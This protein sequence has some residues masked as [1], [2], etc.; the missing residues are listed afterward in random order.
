MHILPAENHLN[1]SN[2]DVVKPNWHFINGQ[3]YV[4][5]EAPTAAKASNVARLDNG[6]LKRFQP[7]WVASQEE[8]EEKLL[9]IIQVLKL[10][11][12]Q[13]NED[14][15]SN[16]ECINCAEINIK[17]EADE[18]ISNH[19]HINDRSELHINPQQE[20]PLMNR[21]RRTLKSCSSLLRNVKLYER[22]IQERHLQIE[23]RRLAIEERKQLLE[24]AKFEQEKYERDQR[25]QVE[26]EERKHKMQIES[27]QLQIHCDLL[28]LLANK[29]KPWR[30]IL[31]HEID[32]NTNYI[33]GNLTEVLRDTANFIHIQIFLRLSWSKGGIRGRAGGSGRP[34]ATIEPHLRLLALRDRMSSTRMV[35]DEFFVDEGIRFTS[36]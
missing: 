2:L 16:A 12:A 1:Y 3:C 14:S 7:D 20:V 13:D 31:D 35:V 10:R 21:K 23:E 5:S 11:S 26:I 32:K 25:L 22:S 33:K 8:Y 19:E 27:Q 17:D 4:R 15:F 28:K 6:M 36:V 9:L 24:E 34:K 29:L 30:S 18:E